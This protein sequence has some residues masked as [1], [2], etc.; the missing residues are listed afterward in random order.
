MAT[1]TGATTFAQVGAETSPRGAA[2]TFLIFEGPDESVRSWTYGEFDDVVGRV[3]GVL[4]REGVGHGSAVHL[5]L[6]NCPTFVAVWIA[7][8][9]LGAFIVPGD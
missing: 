2:Q 4:V 5:A 7:A 8:T 3:A 6:T 1:W 9:R